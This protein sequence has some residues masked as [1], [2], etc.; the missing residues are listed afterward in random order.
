MALVVKYPPAS[1]GAIKD[2]GSLDQE[3]SLGQEDSLEEGMTA[4][5]S[6]IAWRIPWTEE[7]D[8]L[9]F[10]GHKKSKMTLSD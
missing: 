9:Q 4:H 8:G 6:I 7:P 10:I 2:S 3:G 5:F 1:P